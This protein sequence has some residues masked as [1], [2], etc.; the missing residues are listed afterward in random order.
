MKP[1]LASIATVLFG[2]ALLQNLAL[3]DQMN[4]EPFM[5]GI[6]GAIFPI[7]LMLVS[8]IL[9]GLAFAKKETPFI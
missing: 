1:L 4:M 5:E 6:L 9:Y 2:L 7:F 3:A 8:C